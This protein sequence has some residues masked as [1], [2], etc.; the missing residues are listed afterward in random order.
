VPV[1]VVVGVAA[2]R[3]GQFDVLGRLVGAVGQ[4]RAGGAGGPFAAVPEH[5]GE[6]AVERNAPWA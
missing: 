2:T 6:Q 4:V 1:G 3:E 5:G